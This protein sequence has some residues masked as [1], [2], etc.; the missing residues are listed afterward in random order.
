MSTSTENIQERH[1]LNDTWSLWYDYQD[2]KYVDTDNWFDS[3]KLVGEAS[4]AETFWAIQTEVSKVGELPISSNMHFFRKGIKPM[5][6]DK[7]NSEGGK[8]V[9][10][11]P[12]ETDPYAFWENT[13]LFCISEITA[14][15]AIAVKNDRLVI[16]ESSV[17]K[18]FGD[19]VCGAVLSPRKTCTRIS[20]WVRIKDAR[21]MHIG[22]LWK[23]FACIPD[24]T[25][26]GF[27]S[28]E[29]AIRGTKEFSQDMYY[30]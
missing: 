27:K 8:W 14:M 15:K 3:L 22:K 30:I 16:N 5:W 20:L 7:R 11:I 19:V 9:L 1:K 17:D 18:K 24:I 4:D 28:H 2:K 6:E 25:K 29:N 13:L 26:I 12:V 10:E 23:E 21:A